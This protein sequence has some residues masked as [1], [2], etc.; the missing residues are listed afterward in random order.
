MF[1]HCNSVRLIFPLIFFMEP[2][3]AKKGIPKFTDLNG[4]LIFPD[5]V[6][7]R[8]RNAHEKLL[9]NNFLF[10]ETKHFV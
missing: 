9:N 2:S 10:F 6:K 8:T 4:I 1:F 3:K 7:V 5:C